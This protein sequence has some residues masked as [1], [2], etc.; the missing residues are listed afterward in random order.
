MVDHSAPAANRVGAAD[1]VMD[2][3]AK[4]IEVEDIE[5]RV[6]ELERTVST[7]CGRTAAMRDY[8]RWIAP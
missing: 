6:S 5:V 7:E 1:S 4:G 8:I 3:A 2:H